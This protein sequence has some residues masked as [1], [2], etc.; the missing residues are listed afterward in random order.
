MEFD[1]WLMPNEAKESEWDLIVRNDAFSAGMRLNLLEL[2]G[3]MPDGGYYWDETDEEMQRAHLQDSEA[4]QA[5]V[6]I[7]AVLSG[8]LQINEMHMSGFTVI[9]TEKGAAAMGLELPNPGFTD[10]YTTA[11]LTREQETEIEEAINQV[12][13][14]GWLG[15]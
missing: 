1:K 12:A 15:V 10:I 8:P 3:R 11:N 7:G 4:V 9:V 5:Y 13:V 14:K 6:T 2:A